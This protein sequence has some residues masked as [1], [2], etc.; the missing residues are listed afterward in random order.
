LK[1]LCCII[2]LVAVEAAEYPL[3]LA[4]FF[5][6]ISIALQGNRVHEISRSAKKLTYGRP[7]FGFG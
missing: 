5:I 1:A 3:P 4:R 6:V 7:L 2:Y